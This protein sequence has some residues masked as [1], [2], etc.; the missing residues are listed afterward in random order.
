MTALR[1][2]SFKRQICRLI[3]R[4]RHWRTEQGANL[5]LEP[6][7]NLRTYL[8][9][10]GSPVRDANL[11]LCLVR[12]SALWPLGKVSKFAPCYV[13]QGGAASSLTA[14]PICPVP[15]VGAPLVALRRCCVRTA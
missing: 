6:S 10:W 2:L 8:R 3:L 12:W 7:A 1:Q 14:K 11:H 13:R 9:A 4:V 15:P 5:H